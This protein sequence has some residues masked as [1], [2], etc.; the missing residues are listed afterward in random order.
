M[1]AIE[2]HRRTSPTP[3]TRTASKASRNPSGRTASPTSPWSAGKPDGGFR[4]CLATGARR[5]T[6]CSPGR[7]AFGRMPCRIVEGVSDDQAV[8]L[9]HT[10]NYFTRRAQRHRAGQGN[11]GARHPGGADARREPRAE[12]VRTAG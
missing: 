2:D 1:T 3:W 4:C 8:T 12:G 10:A 9:L 7:P 6:R 5:P 11:A